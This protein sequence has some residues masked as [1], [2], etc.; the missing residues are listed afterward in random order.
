[1]PYKDKAKQKEHDLN[2]YYSNHEKRKRQMEEYRHEHKEETKDAN[3]KY[4]EANKEK[5]KEWNRD[6]YKSNREKKLKQVKDYQLINIEKIKE[7]QIRYQKDNK[8]KRVLQNCNYRKQRRMT[9]PLYKTKCNIKRRVCFAF[10]KIKLNKPSKTE[11]LLGADFKTVMRHIE[12]QFIFG[13]S[14]KKVGKEI[15]IDH[16]I[17]LATAK[18]EKQL[19][20]L[21]HYTNLQPLWKEEN[22]S[23]RHK[24]DFVVE[25]VRFG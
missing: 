4:Y 11:E 25:E 2:Y 16:K 6:N 10:S 1:M 19:I 21:C 13:M 24:T 3:I 8:G 17:P 22:L 14:W 15:H 23:K 5:I 20:K 9:D 18:T 12:S 7:Y